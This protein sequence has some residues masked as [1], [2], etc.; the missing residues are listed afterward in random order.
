MKKAFA[1]IAFLVLLG[2]TYMAVDRVLSIKTEDAIG[3]MEKYQVLPKDTVDVLLVGSSHVGMNVDNRLIWDEYGIASYNLWGGMQPLWNS[4]YYV[5]EG[6]KHQQPK[7]VVVEV[8]LAGTEADYSSKD[9]A[10][11]N[12]HALPFG[13]DKLQAALASYPTWQEAAEAVWGLPYYHNRYGELTEQDLTPDLYTRDLGVS[14]INLTMDRVTQVNMLDYSA[15]TAEENLSKKNEEYLYKIIDLCKSMKVELLFLISPYEA[16]ENEA[17]RLNRLTSIANKNGVP[18]LNYLKCWQDIGLDTSVDFYD[19]GHLRKSGIAKL[20]TAIGEY[21]HTHYDLPDRREDTK[22]IWS[23]EESAEYKTDTEVTAAYAMDTQFVGDGV[24]RMIDTGVKL[25][26]TEKDWTLD[27]ELTMQQGANNGVYLSCF[28]EQ[29]DI[30]YRG[31]MIRQDTEDTVTIY[32]GGLLSWCYDLPAGRSRMHVVVVK[33][34]SDYTIAV[35]GVVQTTLTS[36]CV[37]YDGNLLV[38]CQMDAN[39]N[40]FRCGSAVVDALIVQD[41]AIPAD[42]AAERSVLAQVNSRF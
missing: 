1:I 23:T 34:G 14:T 15:I 39:G 4:Y 5:K 41:G 16:K 8:F 9:V 36:S 10:I 31:F 37:P 27:A 12:I 42:E 17:M 7:L 30:G 6:L 18:V 24:A 32:V 21:L 25:F 28:A 33:Q 20:S 26:D 22:H 38:G 19:I 11:K 40:I 35:N 2:C 13:L 3:T 29:P